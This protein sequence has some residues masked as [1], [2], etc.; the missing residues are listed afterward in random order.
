MGWLILVVMEVEAR[1]EAT[2]VEHCKVA[3]QSV[4]I[5]TNFFIQSE[6]EWPQHD[7]QS[8]IDINELVAKICS[9]A[10]PPFYNNHVK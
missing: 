7:R 6:I 2:E 3:S 5:L 1:L 10:C 4:I 9:V 8:I